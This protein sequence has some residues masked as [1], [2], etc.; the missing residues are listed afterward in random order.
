MSV[1]ALLLILRGLFLYNRKLLE[2]KDEGGKQSDLAPR[3]RTKFSVQQSAQFTVKKEQKPCMCYVYN[4]QI[5]ILFFVLYLI[6]FMFP[7]I[8]V[9]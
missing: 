3:A 8:R 6:Q 7:I 1:S 4:K 9:S 2:A 5:T